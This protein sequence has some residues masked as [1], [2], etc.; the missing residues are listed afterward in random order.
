M[1]LTK[2]VLKQLINEVK[3]E[4]TLKENQFAATAEEEAER[5]NDQ[6][7]LSLVTDPEFWAKLGVHTG[8]DL[9][10]SLLAS[11]YSDLYKSIH[12]MRPRHMNFKDMSVEEIQKALDLLDEYAQRV[13]EDEWPND[14]G[15]SDETEEEDL[16]SPERGESYEEYEGFPTQSS[17]RRSESRQ[18]GPAL[19]EEQNRLKKLIAEELKSVLK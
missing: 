10:K 15:E 13:A 1:K 19:R 8:E 18:K 17:M 4:Q 7:G 16:A 12:N 14:R 9:A 6:A 11:S 3:Q 2:S 5:V